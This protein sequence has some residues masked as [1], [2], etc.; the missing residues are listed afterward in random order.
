MV[1]DVVMGLVQQLLNLVLFLLPDS[2][3]QGILSQSGAITPYL[4]Y[5]NYFYDVS[6][7]VTAFETWLA[8]ITLYLIYQL[9]LRWAKAVS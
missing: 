2:P 6:F 9:Y 4:G 1:Q 8:A 3:F 7:A 5:V